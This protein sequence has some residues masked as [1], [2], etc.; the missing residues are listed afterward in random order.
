MYWNQDFIRGSTDHQSRLLTRVG[1]GS[2]AAIGMAAGAFA[3]QQAHDSVPD[4]VLMSID[5]P[6]VAPGVEPGTKILLRG[7]R[8]G[9]VVDMDRSQGGSIN[10]NLVL[11][12]NQTDGLTDS[13]DLDFRPEN[14]FGS[15]AVTLASNPGGDPLTSGS[16]MTKTPVGDFT[17]STMLEKGSLTIDGSLTNDVVSGLDETVHYMDG[18]T[19]WVETGVVVADRVAK[20]QQHVPSELLGKFNDITAE[21]PA[22]IDQLA[23]AL[24][25][26]YHSAY[27]RMPDGSIGLDDAFIE[28]TDTGLS[29]ASSKLFGQAGALLASHGDELVPLTSTVK[30]V[31]DLIPHLDGAMNP[32][33]VRELRQR[34]ESAFTDTGDGQRLR[35]RV[36][37]DNLPAIGSA[38]GGASGTTEVPR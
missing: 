25:I 35:L 22:F 36:V 19:S 30:A 7:Q 14:Y 6:F 28:D 33:Q 26:L 23:K 32:A 21:S 31:S 18:L 15:T 4:G 37:L 24:N 20:S 12:D 27:N 9:E 8:V 3:V 5:V 29:L 1:V 38:V 17:M 10:M 16:H 2:I 13:F 34:V 11:D